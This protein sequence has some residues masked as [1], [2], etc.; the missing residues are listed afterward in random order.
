[1]YY[2]HMFMNQGVDY[3]FTGRQVRGRRQIILL[4]DI[5]FGVF[6]VPKGFLCD[7]ASIPAFAD[8]LFGLDPLRREYLGAAIAHDYAYSS[9]WGSR[10]ECDK[11]FSL[12]IWY[13]SKRVLR[14]AFA[15]IML[16][17]VRIG[18]FEGYY[19][20]NRS[21][22]SYYWSKVREIAHI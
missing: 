7:G 1:V 12:L 16:F 10:W 15:P 4:R 14:F 18:G 6:V 22:L 20:E 17:S 21:L 3:T 5:D 13:G 9:K 11:L 8:N 19:A 2:V